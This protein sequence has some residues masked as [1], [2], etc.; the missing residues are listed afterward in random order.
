MKKLRIFIVLFV[1]LFGCGPYIWYKVPQPEGRKDL[2]FFPEQLLGKYYSKGD[3]SVIRIENS[4][5]VRE[6]REEILLSKIE[7]REEMGDTISEDTS[8]VFAD[9]WNIHIKTVGDSVNVFSSRDEELFSIS[10]Q[11]ILREYRGYYFLNLKDTNDYWKVKVLKLQ[12]D[13][14]EFDHLLTQKDIETIKNITTVESVTDTTEEI[15]KHYLKPS[16][17]EI[18]KI[19]KKRGRGNL[20]VRTYTNL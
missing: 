4:K 7:F 12:G 6:Y 18:K 15:S 5:I 2:P 10:N 20:Y 17:R 13:T 3:S 16:K 9:S 19:L 11:N 8:F 14:L 1:I